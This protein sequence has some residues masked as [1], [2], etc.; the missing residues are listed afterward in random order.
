MLCAFL[1]A[2]LEI[3]YTVLAQLTSAISAF[4]IY[5]LRKPPKYYFVYAGLIA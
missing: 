4:G 2:L 5:K 3:P 1:N